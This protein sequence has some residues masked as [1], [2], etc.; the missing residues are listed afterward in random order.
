MIL[1]DVGKRL[2]EN[3]GYEEVPVA[4][5]VTILRDGMNAMV[6]ILEKEGI[7]ADITIPKFG[8]FTIKR[9]KARIGHNP[10]T[11]EKINIP[12]KASLKFKL[13]S[14]V[15]QKMDALVVPGAAKVKAKEKA[16]TKKKA[17]GK[18]KK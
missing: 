3:Y 6:D 11:G 10:K 9:N 4:D 1:L 14:V 5:I 13:S 17:K 8:K 18:K 16:E 15:K 7:G 12:E 2:N